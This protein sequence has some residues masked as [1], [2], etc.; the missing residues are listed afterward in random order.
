MHD[1]QLS[2]MREGSNLA[3]A[4]KPYD[5]K[6]NSIIAETADELTYEFGVA[7]THE[8]KLYNTELFEHVPG[9]D[10]KI[11][12]SPRTHIRPDGGVLLITIEGIGRMPLLI[13]ENKKQ[14]DGKNQASGNAVERATKNFGMLD[15]WMAREYIN[16]FVFFCWGSDFGPKKTIEDRLIP[17]TGCRHFNEVWVYKNPHEKGGGSVFTSEQPFSEEFMRSICGTVARMSMLYFI[18]RYGKSALATN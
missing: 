1:Y 12:T 10:R 11:L 3:T 5:R 6:I 18:E 13:G 14:G 8:K 9:I 16:P 17:I 4:S 7:V 15:L 2:E